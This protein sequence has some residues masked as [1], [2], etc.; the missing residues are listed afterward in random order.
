MNWDSIY[1]GAPEW[2]SVLG[3]VAAALHI[4]W[5]AGSLHPLN[6][7]L[8]RLFISR[9]DIQDPFVKK[10]LSDYSA[11]AVFRLT[12]GIP[13]RTLVDA[14]K[15]IGKAQARNVPLDLVGLAG[16]AFDLDNFTVIEK[17]R[18]RGV[19]V[20]LCGLMLFACFWVTLIL[21]LGATEQ[22][23][24]ISLNTTGTWLW[25]GKD[26]AQIAKPTLSGKRPIFSVASCTDPSR[27]KYEDQGADGFRPADPNIL[28]GIWADP[29]TS[30]ELMT[31]V[32]E[33]R[34]TFLFASAFLAWTC[35]MLFDGLRRSFAI[36]A[37]ARSLPQSSAQI[38]TPSGKGRYKLVMLLKLGAWLDW[39]VGIRTPPRKPPATG[40][41]RGR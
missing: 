26:Q 19:S 4:C 24:L 27:A 30:A 34:L 22:R 40:A 32:R 7:R 38:D 13:A 25:L 5:R 3:L 2:F 11:L 12:Y 6:N 18:P 39:R 10:N 28:C 35:L 23:L 8:L 17:K 15:I 1:S 37:L 36:R 33:Q 41:R 9:D 20:A 16:S 31:S 29:R 14:K 21:A